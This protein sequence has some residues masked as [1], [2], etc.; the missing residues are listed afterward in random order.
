MTSTHGMWLETWWY[1]K[2]D[3]ASHTTGTALWQWVQTGQRHIV[4]V[5]EQWQGPANYTTSYNHYYSKHVKTLHSEMIRRQQDMEIHWQ[6]HSLHFVR[7][8]KHWQAH[9][10]LLMWLSVLWSEV[11][12][13][14]SKVV[15]ENAMKIQWW[16]ALA[17]AGFFARLRTL[18]PI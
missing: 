14:E 5:L 9:I 13:S 3:T 4:C 15:P 8:T 1:H 16:R 10:T 6:L 17:S 11:K 2:V 12:W 7:G 18:P